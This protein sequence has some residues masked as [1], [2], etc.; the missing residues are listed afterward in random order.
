MKVAIIGG[1]ICGLYLA[2]KLSEK[3]EEVVIFEKNEKIGKETCSG[4]FSEKILE[5]IPDA[6]KLIE[7][8]IDY[9]L[10]HFPK[11]IVKINFDQDFYLI[12]HFKLDNLVAELAQKAGAKIILNKKIKKEDLK[13]IINNFDRIIG[14]DG[15]NSII[16]EYLNLP[17]PNLKIAIQGFCPEK[18]TYNFV[19]TWPTQSGFIWKINRNNEVEW[20]IIE[21]PKFAKKIFKNFIKEK[22][23]IIKEEKMSLIAQGL[24]IAKNKKIAL[25]GEAAGLTKPWSGGGVIWG[26]I[27]CHILLKNFPNFVKF[28]KELKKFFSPKIIFSNFAKKVVYFLGFHLPFLLPKNSK[29]E[30]DFLKNF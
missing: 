11:K 17:K 22:G 5:F 30:N 20:G 21:D 10:I 26:L 1:G 23:I 24:L 4:L 28:E 3:G 12:N 14:A 18:S 27:S 2:W 19:E 15:A 13:E 6:T 9:C 25:V 7:K 29:I 8:K 16:R